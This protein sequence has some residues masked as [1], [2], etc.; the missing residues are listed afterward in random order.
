LYFWHLFFVFY[1]SMVFK[2][3]IKF[4]GCFVVWIRDFIKKFCKTMVFFSINNWDIW[5][6]KYQQNSTVYYFFFIFLEFLEFCFL[7]HLS[8]LVKKLWNF[9][10]CFIGK[11]GEFTNNFL[12][13]LKDLLKKIL[14]CEIFFFSNFCGLLFV[15]LLF[16]TFYFQK[17]CKICVSLLYGS[18]ILSKNWGISNP[19]FQQ[20][21]IV[22]YFFFIFLAYL[23]LCLLFYVPKLIQKLWNFLWCFIGRVTDFTNDF[24]KI[25]KVHSKKILICEIFFFQISAVYYLFFFYFFIS[26]DILFSIPSI[27]T[28]QNMLEIFMFFY[29]M[30]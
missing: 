24:W 26:F 4:L 28:C 1:L 9:L 15:F 29:F 22:F 13:F 8:K 16:L 14:I 21:S 18:E 6:P 23:A 12:K 27:C 7:F 20:N 17:N 11:V 30:D 25:L 5:N 2:K 19:K 10:W 3:I